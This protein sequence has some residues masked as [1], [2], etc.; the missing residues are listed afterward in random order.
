MGSCRGQGSGDEGDPTGG[1]GKGMKG[2]LKLI[3]Q[4]AGDE[5][6]PAE[7]KRQGMKVILQGARSRG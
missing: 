4:G 7:G 2:I 5:R 6:D 3:L 1:K